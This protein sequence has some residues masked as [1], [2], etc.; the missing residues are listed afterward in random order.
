MSA[1]RGTEWSRAEV[2]RVQRLWDDEGLSAAEI[3]KIVG[4]SKNAVIGKVRRMQFALRVSAVGGRPAPIDVRFERV[5]SSA[6]KE[7]VKQFQTEDTRS[8]TSRFCGDPLPGRSAL[9]RLYQNP[10]KCAPVVD[11]KRKSQFIE[12][13]LLNGRVV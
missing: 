1:P 2:E 12:D 11:G 10:G 4:R 3:G 9:D 6:A 13:H 5:T 7:L 8:F